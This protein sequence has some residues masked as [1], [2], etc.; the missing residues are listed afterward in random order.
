MKIAVGMS[1]GVD[2]SVA[3]LLLKKQGH[4][5]TGVT[6]KIWKG[7]TAGHAP[8]GNACYGPEE[9]GDIDTS[10][11]SRLSED[12]LRVYTDGP[13][14]DDRTTTIQDSFVKLH[15]GKI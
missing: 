3:A 7:Q 13:P 2:S 5:I 10:E 11:E 1:G 12:V 8:K 9:A 14:A 15:S 6:M 4:E